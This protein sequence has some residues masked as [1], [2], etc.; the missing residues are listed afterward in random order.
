MLVNIP[1]RS[2]EELENKVK[3]FDAAAREGFLLNYRLRFRIALIH[4]FQPYIGRCKLSL[5]R[6]FQ[7]YA[8]RIIIAQE[9]S[10]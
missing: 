2:T 3:D 10:A 7:A 6:L 8:T 9:M 4:C 1:E 5:I